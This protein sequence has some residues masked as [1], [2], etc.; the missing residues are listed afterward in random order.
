M[1][2]VAALLQSYTFAKLRQEFKTD[3][4]SLLVA[5]NCG[6][7][8]R[9]QAALYNDSYFLFSFADSSQLSVFLTRNVVLSCTCCTFAKHVPKRQRT[10]LTVRAGPH[11]VW[12]INS[13]GSCLWSVCAV[14]CLCDVWGLLSL[15]TRHGKDREAPSNA[16]FVW[17]DGW[18][19][20]GGG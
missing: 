10:S 15:Q 7:D 9:D 18:G 11:R 2:Q 17:M 16:A 20:G 14:Y 5:W 12:F 3:C 13:A 8:C 19:G 1:V 4:F 6:L